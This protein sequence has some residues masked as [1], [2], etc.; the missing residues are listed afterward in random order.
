MDIVSEK[1]LLNNV[2]NNIGNSRKNLGRHW[3]FNLHNDPKRLGFV[4]S[5][6]KFSA[7]MGCKDRHVLELGCSEGIGAPILAEFATSYMGIDLDPDAISAAK[8]NFSNKKMS[9]IED[10]FL[11]EKYGIFETIVSLDV[12]EHIHKEYEPIFFK[13]VCENMGDD[14]LLI[15]GTPNIS[16]NQYASEP[17]KIGHVNMYSMDSLYAATSEFFNNVFMFGMNDEIVHTGFNEMAHYII[18]IGCNKKQDDKK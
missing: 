18:V 7:K 10:D 14:G 1:Q 4:L 16:S 12:I 15:I 9:F 13:T 2:N 17:S 5:R 6:Y 11:G 3:S 8:K